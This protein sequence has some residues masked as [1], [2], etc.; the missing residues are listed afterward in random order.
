MTTTTSPVPVRRS[1]LV[2][3]LILLLVGTVFLV[4][5]LRPELS[6]W[7][8]FAEYYPYLLI[9]WGVARLGE[10]VAARATARPIARTL[11]GGVVFLAF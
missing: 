5:N 4:S 1:S 11:T 2:G 6:V 10:Y 8:L 3:P 9:L 7:R